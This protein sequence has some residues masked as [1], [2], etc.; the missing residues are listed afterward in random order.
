MAPQLKKWMEKRKSL[1][2]DTGMGPLTRTAKMEVQRE[3]LQEKVPQD[4]GTT[5]ATINSIRK[6][7]NYEK[8]FGIF[9]GVT[10][11]QRRM[12][13]FPEDL[14]PERTSVQQEGRSPTNRAALKRRTSIINDLNGIVNRSV[15]NGEL[16]KARSAVQ[17]KPPKK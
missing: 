16:E 4:Y 14:P 10:K 6:R 5:F 1:K 13:L 12:M 8:D 7:I 3:A 15:T 2:N 17:K 11:E 9:R